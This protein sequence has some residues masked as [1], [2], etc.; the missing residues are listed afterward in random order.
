MLLSLL[1][2]HVFVFAVMIVY[3]MNGAFPCQVEYWC[4]CLY[5]PIGIGL[6]QA[7]NQQLLLVSRDQTALITK[8]EFFNPIFP[9]TKGFGGPKYWAFRFKIWWQNV[10][11]KGKCEGF[12]LIGIVI[13]V[14]PH[15]PKYT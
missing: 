4:M 9:K 3:T 11:S 7:Y 14:S 13:Q 8:D 2:I 12:V 5:L 6:Y 10:S 15:Y 1:T